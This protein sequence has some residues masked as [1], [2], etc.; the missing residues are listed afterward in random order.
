[1]RA[2]AETLGRSA[3]GS[4]NQPHSPTQGGAPKLS[5][6]SWASRA[7]RLIAR[8]KCEV[9]NVE[10]EP[11]YRCGAK[12]IWSSAVNPWLGV[13]V[14]VPFLGHRTPGSKKTMWEKPRAAV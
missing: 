13:C 7:S 10:F 2:N 6:D 11:A 12:T 9:K 14:A 8:W 3:P 4:P 5:A 1:M